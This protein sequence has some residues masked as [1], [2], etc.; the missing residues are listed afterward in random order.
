MVELRNPRTTAASSAVRQRGLALRTPRVVRGRVRERQRLAAVLDVAAGTGRG[1]VVSVAGKAGIGKT[2]V[3]AELRAVAADKGFT[4]VGVGSDDELRPDAFAALLT[5]GRPPGEGD[6]GTMLDGRLARGPVLVTVD[7]LQWSHAVAARTLEVLAA[8][9]AHRPLV[10]V[11]AQRSGVDRP[12]LDQWRGYLDEHAE[13]VRIELPRL[14]DEEVAALVGDLL[15]AS[16][17]S[18][19]AMLAGCA[20]GIPA[21]VVELVGAVTDEGMRK[22]EPDL[23]RITGLMASETFGPLPHGGVELP[24]RLAEVLR[25]GLDGLS[26]ETRQVLDVAAVLGRT[27][28]PDD[29]AKMLDQ[30]FA[31]LLPAFREAVGSEVLESAEQGMR[32]RNA[33]LWHVL[34]QD[35]P[36]AVR[37]A[38]H[39]QAATMVVARGGSVVDSARHAARGALYGDE[40]TIGLLRDAAGEA[41]RSAPRVAAELALRGLELLPPGHDACLPLTEIAVEACARSGPVSRAVRLAEDALTGSLPEAAKTALRYWLFTA[42]TLEG[43][44]FDAGRV[45]EFLL[46]DP[47]T[48]AGLR[49]SLAVNQA[50][51]T[52]LCRDQ[53]L[54]ECRGAAEDDFP[55]LAA[56]RSRREGRLT[57]ALAM[58]RKAVTDEHAGHVIGWIW[59][60]LIALAEVLTDL[61]DLD[62]APAVIDEVAGHVDDALAAVPRILRARVELAAG[63]TANAVSEAMAGLRIARD[64]GTRLYLHEALYVLTT[65]VVRGDASQ[66][67]KEDPL[68]T[69]ARAE[70]ASGSSLPLAWVEARL[71]GA[72]GDPS[73]A[74]AVLEKVVCCEHQ[75]RELFIGS[76]GA[77]AWTVRAA[78][79][80]DRPDWAAA[81]V[82]SAEVLA[83]AN[84]GVRAVAAAAAHARGLLDGDP[85]AL[86]AA[87]EGFPGPWERASAAEDLGRALLDSDRESAVRWLERSV[88]LYQEVLAEP[89]A[90]RIRSVLRAAGVV[91]RHWQQRGT[92]ESTGAAALTDTERKVAGLVATGLTNQQVARR[93]FI[94]HHTVAFHLR[95]VFRK[96]DVTSRVELARQFHPSL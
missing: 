4:V 58:C 44:H 85:A 17:D 82:A 36:D 88:A 69:W 68:V 61:E 33:L 30:P 83:A 34:L 66:V 28:L 52:V 42:L 62:G 7:G 73:A 47:E 11:V 23:A 75:R 41:L 10:C 89:D 31:T 27:F 25:R 91:R 65:V 8:R 46:S 18:D 87:A 14:S 50:H 29:L 6:L 13:A 26:D 92:G 16:P 38:L 22:G 21:T 5:G 78:L 59:H 94:S 84:P 79:A 57:E 40:P 56:M 32:F 80:D 96:L 55:V 71:A 77:A 1:A 37:G 93:M 90:A 15:G 63:R 35:M 2:T 43:R 64:T 24:R 60:P 51:V 3:L 19:L 49:H 39:R 48:P 53:P 70:S 9:A 12:Y 67:R 54:P 72:H 86:T 81:A 95:K 20:R 74:H 45:A 76:S